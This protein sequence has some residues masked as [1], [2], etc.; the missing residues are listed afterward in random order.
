M[1]GDDRLSLAKARAENKLDQFAQDRDASGPG[2][3]TAF[4]RALASM[5]GTSKAT[6]AASKLPRSDD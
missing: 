3:E 6:P 1:I 4:N 5:A 2:D